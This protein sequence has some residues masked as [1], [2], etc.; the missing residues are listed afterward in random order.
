MPSYIFGTASL[1][2][3]FSLIEEEKD[4]WG[5]QI[6]L[7]LIRMLS[8]IFATASLGLPRT[9]ILLNWEGEGRLRILDHPLLDQDADFF[10]WTASLGPSFSLIEEE[11]EP[12]GS[13]IILYLIRMPKYIFRT[14]SLGSSFSLIE[15]E[16]E[17]WGSLII[18]YMIRMP[19]YIFDIASSGYLFSLIEEEKE[20]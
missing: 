16:K 10:F 18:L 8:Y 9:V 4:S 5:S 1:E 19:S 11:K 20:P 2:P 7:Y 3:V 14:A 17:P 15:E 13:M 12:W 6:I